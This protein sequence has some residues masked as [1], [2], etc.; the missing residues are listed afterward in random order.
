MLVVWRNVLNWSCIWTV[1][2]VLSWPTGFVVSELPADWESYISPEI[3]DRYAGKPTNDP[4]AELKFEDDILG[5]DLTESETDTA[6]TGNNF[7]DTSYSRWSGGIVPFVIAP[8][9]TAEERLTILTSLQKMSNATGHCVTFV[10]RVHHRDFVRFLRHTECSSHFG[11]QGGGQQLRLSPACAM[12]PGDIQHEAMH[13]LGFLHEMSRPDRDQHIS[14][15]YDNILQGNRHNFDIRV[16]NTRTFGLPYDYASIMHYPVFAAAK[17]KTK[18]TIIPTKKPA[19]CIGQ[20]YGLSFL[21]VV[22]IKIAYGCL[23]ESEF[24]ATNWTKY[25]LENTMCSKVAL[26]TSEGFETGKDYFSPLKTHRLILQSDKNL[27]MYRECDGKPVFA[28]FTWGF[29]KVKAELDENGQFQIEA[30]TAE[31][32]QPLQYWGSGTWSYRSSELFVS[33]AGYFYLCNYAVGC[34]WRSSGQLNNGCNRTTNYFPLVA[35]NYRVIIKAGEDL[36]LSST[37]LSPNEEFSLA[38]HEEKAIVVWR[39]CDNRQAFRAVARNA[40]SRITLHGTGNLAAH[41]ADGSYI[42]WSDTYGSSQLKPELRLYDNGFLYLCDDNGC[43]WQSSGFLDKCPPTIPKSSY[44]VC[45]ILWYEANYTKRETP[46][47]AGTESVLHEASQNKFS[48]A[49]VSLGCALTIYSEVNYAGATDTLSP[50][51]KGYLWYSFQNTSWDNAV[52]SLR[53]SCSKD[54]MAEFLIHS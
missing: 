44:K 5:I 10:P 46:V 11:R 40:I 9:F 42:W 24:Q 31:E 15:N 53:C 2:I 16:R 35:Y 39:R 4:S 22:K 45:A 7:F 12:D 47:L 25:S 23:S 49:K 8:S 33:D 29:P 50:T 27:V 30:S 36:D 14:I 19:Q 21:D 54:E 34:Y 28:T 26:R 43:Y 13:A 38:V 17:D 20:K 3:L 1:F 32:A 51:R 41:A 6:D 52:R 37:Y 18:P 48:S